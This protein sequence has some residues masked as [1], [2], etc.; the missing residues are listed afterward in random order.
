MAFAG[1][2]LIAFAAF[3]VGT[4]LFWRFSL[5]VV[6]DSLRAGRFHYLLFGVLIGMFF[7][8]DDSLYRLFDEL[9]YSLIGVVLV[10]FGFQTGLTFD[11]RIFRQ[12]PNSQILS[13]STQI[14]AA[15]LLMVLLSVGVGPLLTRYLGVKGGLL[16]SS[17][18]LGTIAVSLRHPEPVFR[19]GKRSYSTHPGIP[20]SP[21]ALFNSAGLILFGIAFPATI[22]NSVF[23]FGSF[24]LVGYFGTLTL[25]LGLGLLL[26]FAV[27]FIFRAYRESYQGAFLSIGIMFVIGGLCIQLQIPGLVAGFLGGSW[28]INTTVRKRE[29][30]EITDRSVAIIGPIFFILLGSFIGGYGGSPFFRTGPLVPF[31]VALL[32]GRGL[33][34]MLGMVISGRLWSERKADSFGIK[35]SWPPLGS[36]SICIAVQ[37][38][39]LPLELHHN[40]LIAGTV[41][42]VFLSQLVIVSPQRS[43]LV[44]Q[45]RPS[46][47]IPTGG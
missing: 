27:D 3:Y 8:E 39:H 26:G 42:A 16:L 21:N 29:V 33:V 24:A 9:R 30:L 36:L 28:L 15:F 32:I 45:A 11:F 41:L 38:I 35:F 10:A 31:A 19:W 17:A 25:L 37:A 5:P 20:E 22:E 23:Q 44:S 40:T 7:P 14:L 1:I 43:A 18:L 2:I 6:L 46:R 4:H 34:R 12:Y 47:S 13:L